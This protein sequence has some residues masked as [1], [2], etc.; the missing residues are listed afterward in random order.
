MGNYRAFLFSNDNTISN[1]SKAVDSG[2]GVGDGDRFAT[3]SPTGEVPLI[4]ESGTLI[5]FHCLDA[6][7]DP[8][9]EDALVIRFLDESESAPIQAE[10]GIFRDKVH[11]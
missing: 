5:W 9:E 10:I 6:T 8:I 4:R 7:V 11:E 1:S 3:L 2:R